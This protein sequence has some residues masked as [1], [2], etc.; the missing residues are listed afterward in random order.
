MRVNTGGAVGAL[1]L[2]IVLGL[3][4][5][6]LPL[7]GVIGTLV[8]VAAVICVIVGLVLLVLGLIRR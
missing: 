5:A 1:I 6:L 3:L 7:P 2:G 4:A 8:Y